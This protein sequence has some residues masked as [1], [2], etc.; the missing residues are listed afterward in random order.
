MNGFRQFSFAGR[1]ST[2]LALILPQLLLAG[3]GGLQPNDHAAV[4]L[5]FDPFEFFSGHTQAWGVV[6]DWR[7]RVTRQF[8]VTIEG[9]TDGGVL[10]L[11]EAFEY[12]DG[13]QSQRVWRI[14]RDDDGRLS[15]RANDI[16]GQ[17]EGAT[18][19]NAMHFRYT[20][21]LSVDGRNISVDFDDW[22]WQ[23]DGE[24]L[25]NRSKIKKLGITVGAFTLFM[26]RGSS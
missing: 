11:D 23:I 13:E 15:G 8:S 9:S 24:T 17:A 5:T 6:Q 18:G 19:G 2:S 7:G 21:Y 1:R 3:C 26:R 14:E 10:T 22:M 16:V 4:A 20:M 12:A 25:L